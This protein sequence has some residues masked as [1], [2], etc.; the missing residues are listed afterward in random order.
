MLANP[1]KPQQNTLFISR[2]KAGILPIASKSALQLHN[3]GSTVVIKEIDTSVRFEKVYNLTVANTHN[4]FVGGD[5]VL[6]HNANKGVCH[7]TRKRA[8]EAAEHPRPGKK[9]PQPKKNAPRHKRD[10]YDEQQ[11]YKN[12]ERHPD[13]QYPEN[14]YHD[15][16]KSKRKNNIHHTFPKR[17]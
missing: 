8:K 13:S 4:Y 12:P 15:A 7:S 16:D 11:K 3:N 2:A 5:G 6:V 9:K 14:H 17:F 1:L 10:E